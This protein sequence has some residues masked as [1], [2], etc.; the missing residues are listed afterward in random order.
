MKVYVIL[1]LFFL[2]TQLF[3]QNNNEYLTATIIGSGSPKFNTERSGPSVL[4]SYKNTHI[5][6]DMGNG[7]QAN[8][9]KAGIKIKNI[10]GLL[11]THHH[12][13]HNE[14]FAPIFIKSLLGGNQIIIA[15]PEQTT[16][17]VDNILEIYKEDI[18]Y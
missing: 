14:E 9:N 17:I 2:N 16:S 1:I 4:I 11:F 12:L 18:T 5:L 6:V 3:S 15:G 7:T 8:L 10:D 13:D